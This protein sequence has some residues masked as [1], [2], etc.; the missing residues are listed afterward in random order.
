MA[1]GLGLIFWM[2]L[3][4][5]PLAWVG[6][7]NADD[8]ENYG[9]VI[10][11]VSNTLRLTVRHC[12]WRRGI[13]DSPTPSANVLCKVADNACRTWEQRTLVWV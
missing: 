8:S 12:L 13:P 4:F 11:I 1:M 7:A 9:T 6:Q 5:S 3:L 10:G 2:F